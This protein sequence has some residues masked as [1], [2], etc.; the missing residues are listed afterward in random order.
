MQLAAIVGAHEP[1]TTPLRAL[2][3]DA[4][5]TLIYP[6]EPI[7]QVYLEYAR[8]YGCKFSEKEILDNFRRAFETPWTRSLLRYEGDGWSFWEFIV[9]QSTGCNDPKMLE[10]LYNHYLQ[11]SAWKLAPGALDVLAQI[12]SSGMKLAVVSNFDT[13]LRPLLTT[14]GAADI[15]DALIISAEVGAEKPNPLIF[16]I[17]CQQLGV[18]PE[19]TVH[20]GDDRRNDITGARSAGCH[21]WLWGSD[22]KS[23]EEVAQQISTFNSALAAEQC[24]SESQ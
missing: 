14:M 21:A 3:V 4:A 20:V 15:F 17:A 16:E 11:P 6:S 9:E 24:G 19:E 18:L 8:P 12:K 23:F 22:V 7:S 1:Q 2:L 13:R 5:G 10:K